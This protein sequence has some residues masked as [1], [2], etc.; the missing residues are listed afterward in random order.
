[1]EVAPK[2][3]PLNNLVLRV[4]GGRRSYIDREGGRERE[5]RGEGIAEPLVHPVTKDREGAGNS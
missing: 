5:R 4:D 2:E 1:M 3:L